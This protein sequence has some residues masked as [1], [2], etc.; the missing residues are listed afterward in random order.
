M[1]NKMLGPIGATSY[2]DTIALSMP[3]VTNGN[4]AFAKEIVDNG[5]GCLFKLNEGSLSKALVQFLEK[6][7]KLHNA[8]VS[9][10]DSL[11]ISKYTEM[12]NKFLF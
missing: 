2:M 7:N 10:S 8:M 9:F 6:Y 11:S 4:A 1:I 12:L 5:I 3:V